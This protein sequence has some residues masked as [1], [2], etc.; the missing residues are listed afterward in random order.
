MPNPQ[1]CLRR[2]SRPYLLLSS[3]LLALLLLGLTLAAARARPDPEPPLLLRLRAGWVDPAQGASPIPPPLGASSAPSPYAIVQ[4]R[5]PIRPEWQDALRAAGARVIDYLPD[6]AYVVRLPPDGAERLR[7]LPGVRWVS[8]LLP[9][10]RVDPALW[11]AHGPLT[12]TVQLF[13]GEDPAAVAHLPGVEPLSTARTRWQTT[14]RVRVDSSLVPVLAVLPGV[15]WIEPFTPPQL[16]NDVS[17]NLIGVPTV[18]ATLGLTGSGQTIAVADTGLDVGA[19]GPITDFAGR[20]LATYCLGRPSPCRWDDPHGHGTHVAGSALGSGALS[21]GQFAGVAP[22]ARL[23]VQSLYSDT[24]TPLSVPADLNLLFAPPYTDGARIHNDSWGSAGNRY[25]TW[26]QTADQFVW[27]HPEMLVVVAAG[28]GGID[29][30]GDGLVDPGSLY[31]PATA[32]NVLAVGASES[33][34]VGEGDTLAYG[35]HTGAYFPANPVRNDLISDDPGGLAAFSSRGPAFDGRVRPDLVAPGTNIVSARSHHPDATYPYTYSAHY[36]YSSGSSQAAP[37]VSGAAALVRQWYAQHGLP[38]PS[39]ALVKATLIHGAIDLSPGQ[40]GPA[41]SGTVVVSDDVEG[42]GVWTSTTWVV[43]STWDAHSPDHAWVAEGS[44][45]FQRLD[46]VVDLSGTVSPTL[47]FWNRRS[48]SGSAARVYAC[49]NQRVAYDYDDS[50]RTGW[51]QE[52]VDVGNCGGETTALIRFELQCLV[53]ARCT[54]DVWAVDDIQVVDGGRL[55]EVGP[56][57]DPGQGWGRLNLTRTLVISPPLRRWYFDERPGLQTGQAVGYAV[58]I[59]RSTVPLR[60]TL[61]WSDY[62]ASPAAAVALVNDLD[63]ELETPGGSL[64]YPNGLTR[65]DR[66]NNVEQ[67][68]VLSPTLG[69]YRLV[70]RGY[71]VPFGPQPYALVVTVGGDVRPMRV[72]LPLVARNGP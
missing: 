22:G 20:I 66:T 15:R 11:Q 45:G 58:E 18:R 48:L 46:A 9:A 72:Y 26:A 43:T 14:L 55:A 40:Y 39:A 49:G 50:P 54:A 13:P 5:G 7:N 41:V 63:L 36:A 68:E 3:L 60:I 25:D 37:L 71:N 44:P 70:V 24:A 23:V 21:G 12:L 64:L 35:E 38:S 1:V 62:P 42:T 29:R 53:P 19:S 52:G 67:I 56:P 31:S 59:T 6:Y 32:K 17:G 34:R 27:D 4:F 30:G 16:L 33:L 8:D 28:N 65:P 57:P 47:L 2:I 61:A 10:F 69:T 51:A